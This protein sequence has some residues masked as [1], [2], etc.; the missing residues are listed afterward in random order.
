MIRRGQSRGI[1]LPFHSPA[2]LPLPDA[3]KTMGAQKPKEKIKSLLSPSRLQS[4]WAGQGLIPSL[5][6]PPAQQ[7]PPTA[8][9][10]LSAS[11]GL[12]NKAS[13]SLRT[14]GLLSRAV[15]AHQEPG[16]VG[17]ERD[18]AGRIKGNGCPA[19]AGQNNL[20]ERLTRLFYKFFFFSITFF[21]LCYYQCRFCL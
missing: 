5:P 7:S 21:S 3:G 13:V 15:S 8:S 12:I 18:G 16:P 1:K 2:V 11:L 10:G 6:T 14:R 19:P 20:I 4:P 17:W 9:L